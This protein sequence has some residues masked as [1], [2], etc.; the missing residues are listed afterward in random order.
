MYKIN[1][2]LIKRYYPL[3]SYLIIGGCNTIFSFLLFTLFWRFFNL[4]YILATTCTYA[5]TACVQFFA[6]R[7]VS[8]KCTSGNIRHQMIKYLLMLATNYLVTISVMHFNVAILG[9]SP[10]IGMCMST[11]CTA[12]LSFILFKF[13]IFK[14]HIKV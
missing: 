5:M 9:L 12:T 4:N 8:F 13:W 14:H 2:E 1:P 11:A 10:Y 6:N 3:L 7:K